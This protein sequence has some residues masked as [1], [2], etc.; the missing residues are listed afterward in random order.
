MVSA[1][2]VRDDEQ[3]IAFSFE[4][5]MRY[6]GPGS[7][8]GV[9]H[10]FKVLE[11]ALPLLEPDDAPQR[12]EITVHTAFGGP[13]A[14][15]AFE[16]VTRAVTED[17][18]VLDPELERAERGRALARFVFR[19][20]YRDH[21]VTLMVREGYVTDEFIDLARMADRTSEQ[22]ARLTELKRAMADRVMSVPAAEVYEVVRG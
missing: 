11:R 8:G 17:R 10:A 13:G 9:A 12:R 15:D 18:Y 6:H 21:E 19:L 14:R 4:D 20:G 2:V 1:I 5:M 22:E 3:A 16:L 7:P